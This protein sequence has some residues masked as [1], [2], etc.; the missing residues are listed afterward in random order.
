MK[1]LY[2]GIT[3]ML[4]LVLSGCAFS[5]N[6]YLEEDGS[7]RMSFQMDGSQLMNMGGEDMNPEEAIDSVISFRKL[8][9]EKKDS[10][11][12]LPPEEQA[13]LKKLENFSMRMLID[14]TEKNMLFDLFTDFGS[15]NE[16]QDAFKAMSTAGGLDPQTSSNPVLSMGQSGATEVNYTYKNNLFTRNAR[17]V[18]A[19]LHRQMMDSV[20]E[21]QMMFESSTYKLQYHFP[22]KIKS[23]SNKEALFS[24]DRK[25]FT[26]E[27]NFM[28]YMEHPEML[29]LEVEL[30]K[31]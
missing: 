1:N 25:S 13:R 11:S 20:S 27:V 30:Q 7:G 26:L 17:I 31:K 3:I 2:V 15:I 6:I 21:V 23:V 10:I 28:E 5:E 29:N 14:P 9:E 4:S 22:K 8:F 12:Q 24:D 19:E 18:D 16:L